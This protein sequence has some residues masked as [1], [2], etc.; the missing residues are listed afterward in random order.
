M[1]QLEL[2]GIDKR[3]RDVFQ[4]LKKQRDVLLKSDDMK[5]Q[6]SEETICPPWPQ[7]DVDITK[8]AMARDFLGGLTMLES[9]KRL[10][11]CITTQS[12]IR[13]DPLTGCE[14]VLA[15]VDPTIKECNSSTSDGPDGER[16]FDLGM[17]L[18]VEPFGSDSYA[19]RFVFSSDIPAPLC[20]SY[21]R[22]SALIRPFPMTFTT[23]AFDAKLFLSYLYFI[24]PQNY[25]PTVGELNSYHPGTVIPN[26]GEVSPDYLFWIAFMSATGMLTPMPLTMLDTDFPMPRHPTSNWWYIPKDT[27]FRVYFG[28]E[29]ML[30]IGNGGSTGAASVN[31][32]IAMRSTVVDPTSPPGF[33]WVMLEPCPPV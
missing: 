1:T 20:D 32:H 12:Y 16:K 19:T 8:M 4:D 31:G 24:C 21:L 29:L 17:T 26:S 13:C 30:W 14:E 7:P 28:M 3:P 33:I 9:I 25:T 23:S 10:S 18:E 5:F 27:P 6:F 2:E 15:P 11:P 22:V